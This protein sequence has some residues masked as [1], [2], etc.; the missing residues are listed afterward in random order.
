M[1][2]NAFHQRLIGLIVLI[3]WAPETKSEDLAEASALN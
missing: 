3:A 1:A 2:L